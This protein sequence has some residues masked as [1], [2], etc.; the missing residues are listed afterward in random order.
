[1][2]HHG[3]WTGVEAAGRERTLHSTELAILVI[4]PLV[5]YVPTAYNHALII[6]ELRVLMLT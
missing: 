1:M 6:L 5:E 3:W 2:T 4:E